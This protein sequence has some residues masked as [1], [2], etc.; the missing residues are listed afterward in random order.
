M[1]GEAGEGKKKRKFA[2]RA[3]PVQNVRTHTV[4]LLHVGVLKL[5]YF[6]LVQKNQ[7]LGKKMGPKA[8]YSLNQTNI[9]LAQVSYALVPQASTPHAFS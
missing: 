7:L 8:G 6:V 3:A 2:Q 4:N 1:W 5:P 9:S